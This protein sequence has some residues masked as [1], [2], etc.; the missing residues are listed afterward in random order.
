MGIISNGR[1]PKI[2]HFRKLS[3]YREFLICALEVN[4]PYTNAPSLHVMHKNA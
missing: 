3:N 4:S 1:V 2:G